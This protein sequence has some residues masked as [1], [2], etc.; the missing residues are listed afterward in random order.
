MLTTQRLEAYASPLPWHSSFKTL[1]DYP[2]SFLTTVLSLQVT[3]KL[4][5]QFPL[6]LM[7]DNWQVVQVTPLSVC[8]T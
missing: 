8:G 5:F 1:V 4:Y 3:Q 2:F 6:V 7:V